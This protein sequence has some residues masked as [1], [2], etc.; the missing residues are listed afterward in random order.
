M[1]KFFAA[2]DQSTTGTKFIIFDSLGKEFG[3]S[4]KTHTQHTNLPGCVSHD[5]NEI[6]VNTKNVI[7]SGMAEFQAKGFTKEN[8]ISVGI[9]NQR[10]TTVCWNKDT[11]NPI[12]RAIAWCDNRSEKTKI[13]AH[14]V[15]THGNN[16]NY[17][18]PKNGLVVSPYYSMFNL[19]WMFQQEPQSKALM[20]EKKLSFGTVDSWLVY[21]LTS[22]KIHTTDVSNASG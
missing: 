11:G 21:K 10:Q 13:C 2:I 20:K 4:Y 5:A 17:F 1:K 8:L 18:K 22:H 7:A 12:R 3:K 14:V 9:T 19:L 16:P 15:E 6:W